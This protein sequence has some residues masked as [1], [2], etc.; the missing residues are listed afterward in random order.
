MYASF[1]FLNI[2]EF[3]QKYCVN[4]QNMVKPTLLVGKDLKQKAY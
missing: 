4:N 3:Y 2:T 1:G